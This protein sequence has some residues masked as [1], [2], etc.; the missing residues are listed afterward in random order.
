MELER[1]RVELA[2][3]AETVKL[4]SASRFSGLRQIAEV[5]YRARN[6]ARDL[7]ALP[8]LRTSEDGR[9][10]LAR[11]IEEY[12]ASLFTNRLVLRESTFHS[13]HDFKAKLLLF[14]KHL[15]AC[16]ADGTEPA[17]SM[18]YAE[19][20]QEL[21]HAWAVAIELL[22]GEEPRLTSRAP[23]PSGGGG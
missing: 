11:T 4:W 6:L 12:E 20:Y 7:V 13:L 15:H 17:K 5:G 2:A 22:Q 1:V 19:Q 8:S 21:D 16:S 18:P 23:A 3:V 14:E 9:L 10:S